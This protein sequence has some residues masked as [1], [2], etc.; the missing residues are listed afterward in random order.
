MS[1]GNPRYRWPLTG[2]ALRSGDSA[3]VPLLHARVMGGGSSIMGM[4]MLRGVPADYDG[5][6]ASGAD[7]WG[8]RDVLPWFCAVETDLDFGGPLHGSEGPTTI[9]RHDPLGWPPIARAAAS[10]AATRGLPFV[11]DMNGDFRDGIG[12]LPIAGTRDRRASS[13][14]AYLTP[15]VRARGNLNILADSHA[16]DLVWD[17]RRV[18][19]VRV[20]TRRGQHEFLAGRTVLSMGALLSPH[21]LLSQGIGAPE[22]LLAAGIPVR[23]ALPG[24]GRNLQNHA[25][26]TIAAQ[27][28]RAGRQRRPERNHNNAMLRYSSG[29]PE[30]GPTDM[31][32]MMGSRVTWHSVAERIAH[33]APVLMA[34]ASRGRVTIAGPG[35]RRAPLV[36]YDLLGEPIDERRLT[37]SLDLLVP[38][39]AALREARLV[40]APS[41]VGRSAVAARFS[42]LNRRNRLA[43][44]V[45]ATVTDLAPFLGE[46]LIASLGEAGMGWDDIVHDDESRGAFIRSKVSPLAHH[47]GTCRMG[48]ADD[49][50]AVVDPAGSVRG[51]AGLS[52]V[53][54][55]V[56]P[57]VPRGN[58]NLPTLMIAEKMADAIRKLDRP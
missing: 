10:F 48:R 30:T 50:G 53:D 34:P 31:A 40:G 47:A 42:A 51:V 54:A 1:Y 4:I 2:H 46:I 14:T 15:A 35:G 17:G 6:A 16:E 9:R 13:A 29:E 43:T 21:F 24:V 8:W 56:M 11:A 52:V 38:L 26:L 44:R 57:T 32:L 19:G 28:K 25:A 18:V 20:S 22:Q 45:I 5:W 41:P 12:A 58:T 39:L 36:E 55:S 27:I 33:F 7:G 23:H 37:A 3:A 49:Q